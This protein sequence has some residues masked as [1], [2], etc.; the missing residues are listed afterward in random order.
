MLWF[1]CNDQTMFGTDSI[2]MQYSP[3]HFAFNQIVLVLESIFFS[4]T[5]D[6]AAA[7]AVGARI[8]IIIIVVEVTFVILT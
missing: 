2:C 4:N 7:P 6:D 1:F 8:I 5:L 3:L